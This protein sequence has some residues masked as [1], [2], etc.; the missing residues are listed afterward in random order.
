MK[1]FLALL[2][3]LLFILLVY[4]SW[5]WYKTTVLCCDTAT[6]KMESGVLTFKYQSDIPIVTEGWSL[7]RDEIIASMSEGKK[8]LIASPYFD[9]ETK[10]LAL[11]RGAKIKELFLDKIPADQ[12]EI[13]TY[14][15]GDC[16]ASRS[17]M[18]HKTTFEWIGGTETVTEKKDKTIVYFDYNKT[19]EIEDANVVTYLTNTAEELK[20]SGGSIKITGHTD[21]DGD[22]QYNDKLGL[23]RADHVKAFLVKQG[24]DENKVEVDSKGELEP[25]AEGS[26]EEAKKQNRR[27]EIFFK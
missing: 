13:S 18:Y 22:S 17:D 8:L 1:N 26:S 5:N 23:A 10:E 2:S 20:K 25:I 3:V 4:L 7:K 6:T 24:V 15:A 27:A 12:I 16:E 9:G 14:A 21:A 11:A 19:N